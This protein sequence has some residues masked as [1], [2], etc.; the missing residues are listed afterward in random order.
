MSKPYD[1]TT[2]D[3]LKRDPPSWMDY[4]RLS[5]GGPIQSLDTD[6][7]TISAQVDQVY[8]VMGRRS[9]LIHV[10]MQ[11][12]RDSRLA[13]RLWR[14]NAL[15]DL[16][17]NLRVRSVALLLRPEADSKKLTGVLE[18]RLPSKK[19]VVTFTYEVVRAWEQPVEPIITGPLATLPMAT[20]ADVPLADLPRLLERIDSRLVAEAPPTEAVRIMTSTLTLA[21]MRLDRDVIETLGRR[22]RTMNI[23]KDSSFYQVLQKWEGEAR[24]R[25]GE[26]KHARKILIRL[27]RLRFGRL[28]KTTR[29][30]IEA[31]DDLERLDHLSE[32]LLSATSWDDMLAET[33]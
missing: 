30:A 27:G 22:L 15:L 25:G 9:H 28:A 16:K 32:R 10:E 3:L 21:G 24:E 13:R 29:A 5:P 33:K 17:H 2:K 4:L 23:L 11:S 19:R 20:L 1:V 18:L 31:I 14:Y 12:H 6:V 26:I 8:R 7:S